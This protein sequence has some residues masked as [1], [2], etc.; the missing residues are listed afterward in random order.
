MSPTGTPKRK[1]RKVT[2]P[3]SVRV[4]DELWERARD[5]ADSEGVTMSEVLHDF[6]EA[7]ANGTVSLERR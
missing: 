3:R 5:R 4:P 7:Y 1:L 6:I 2:K